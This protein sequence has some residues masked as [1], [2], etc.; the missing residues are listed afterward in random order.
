MIYLHITFRKISDEFLTSAIS[1]LFVVW[2][3]ATLMRPAS[4][5]ASDKYD[6]V[7]GRISTELD[8]SCGNKEVWTSMS[9]L[10]L[11]L[12]FLVT[13]TI[14]HADEIE[15]LQSSNHIRDTYV[16]FSPLYTFVIRIVQLCALVICMTRPGMPSSSSVTLVVIMLLCVLPSVYAYFAPSGVS[17]MVMV[18]PLRSGCFLWTSWTAI[19]CLIRSQSALDEHWVYIGWGII[20]VVV[21]LMGIYMDNIEREAHQKLLEENGLN[22]AVMELT[23]LFQDLM[24]DSALRGERQF[25]SLVT[26]CYSYFFVLFY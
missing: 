7:D 4:C 14:L 1:R 19:C 21:T 6:A 22:Q 5:T 11:L 23:E 10:P 15:L 24:L 9:A 3:M 13:S 25:F 2:I 16:R 8:L 12:Y 18:S 20:L 17:S 26:M